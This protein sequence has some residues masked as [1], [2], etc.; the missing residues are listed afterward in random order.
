[1]KNNFKIYLIIIFALF[2]DISAQTIKIIFE[3]NNGKEE[4]FLKDLEN[5]NFDKFD[6]QFTLDLYLKSKDIVNIN[7]TNDKFLNIS[8]K[9]ISFTTLPNNNNTINSFLISEIDS[10]RLKQNL[11]LPTFDIQELVLSEVIF[12]NFTAPWGLA[13]INDNE[14][15]VTEK[16]GQLF[17]VNI[18]TK[19]KVLITNTP[20]SSTNGQGGLLDVKLH[21]DFKNNSLIYLSQAISVGNNQTT[22]V[23]RAKLVNNNLTE[24]REVFRALPLR[25][26][27]QHF[28]SR[29]I[30]DKEGK[31]YVST[32]DRGT[33]TLA[34]DSSTNN[35]KLNRVNADGTIPSDNPFVNR[36]GFRPEIFTSG[37]RNIQG[38][39]IHPI[40]GEIYINEH[41]PQG[42]DELNLVKRGANY[43]WP[44][45]TFG[46]NYGGGV[47]TTDTTYPGTTDPLTYWTPSI[48][49][50][51]MT[52]VKRDMNANEADILITAL[53]GQ[54]IQRLQ[55][56]NNKVIKKIVCLSGY[57]RFRDVK[58]SPNGDI[59][60]ITENPG[61]IIKLKVK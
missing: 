43:A 47:I 37:N 6:N 10:I 30:F 27:G 61:R 38:M 7:I 22:V 19:A 34:Q 4:Y 55:L 45:A 60:A 17:W 15:L 26:S 23:N 8:E 16:G 59:Y 28:G 36:A 50:C 1:M 52:F 32:G 2:N 13:F 49:P 33:P 25:N 46:V 56:L 53:A 11:N 12:S 20:T 39:D 48:A 51:G 9:V 18:Q 42:G 40:T 29:M 5:I 24:I 54:Q 35:G 57:G 58:Q 14:A 3:T 41:G 21:P 44:L 31:L